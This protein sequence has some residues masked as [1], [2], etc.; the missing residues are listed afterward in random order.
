MYWSIVTIILFTYPRSHFLTFT[1]R[2]K[3]Q[4]FTQSQ[5]YLYHFSLAKMLKWILTYAYSVKNYVL[6]S[7]TMS[8]WISTTIY[9]FINIHWRKMFDGRPEKGIFASQKTIKVGSWISGVSTLSKT[10]FLI[11]FRKIIILP[12]PLFRKVPSKSLCAI[13]EWSKSFIFLMT[14]GWFQMD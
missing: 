10:Y 13:L 3:T 12:K 11:T 8:I 4:K 14:V 9:L 5:F 1:V 2:N 6:T 7:E